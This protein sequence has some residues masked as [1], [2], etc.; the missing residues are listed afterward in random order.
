MSFKIFLIWSSGGPP[1]QWSG[2][3]YAILN[4]G[5]I[6]NIHGKLYEIWTS[7]S[8][9]MSFK[10]ISYLELWQPLRS[11]DWILLC[12]SGRRHHEEGSCV[13]ILNLDK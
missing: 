10:D 13:I 1:L 6:G 3:I 5:I 9:E 12:N 7:G 2:T 8:G 11:V 4:K